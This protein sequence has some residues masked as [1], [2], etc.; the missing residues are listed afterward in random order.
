MRGC[1]IIKMLSFFSLV[2]A[3]KEQKHTVTPFLLLIVFSSSLLHTQWSQ[4]LQP[5]P[6]SSLTQKPD[7]TPLPFS[8]AVAQGIPLGH[9]LHLLLLI[10]LSWRKHTALAIQAQWHT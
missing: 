6:T 2:D 10:T 9:P 3:R 5:F 8:S 7:F 1:R 4:Y